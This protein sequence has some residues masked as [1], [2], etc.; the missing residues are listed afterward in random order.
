MCHHSGDCSDTHDIR[1]AT[2]KSNGRAHT[3][4]AS[5]QRRITHRRRTI[6]H[7]QRTHHSGQITSM[8]SRTRMARTSRGVAGGKAPTDLHADANA[9]DE[10]HASAL[11]RPMMSSHVCAM[12]L[13]ASSLTLHPRTSCF[14]MRR[15][16]VTGRSIVGAT[17]GAAQQSADQKPSRLRA[18]RAVWPARTARDS[19][20]AS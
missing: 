6:V 15:T 5:K 3:P 19:R 18:A 11:T 7:T 16:V 4:H 17:G 10:C 12:H 20:S 1:S 2:H 9:V 13:G 14:M 8:A